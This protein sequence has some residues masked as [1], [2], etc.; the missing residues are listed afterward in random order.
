MASSTL[1]ATSSTPIFELRRATIDRI[2]SSSCL[3]QEQRNELAPQMCP[4]SLTSLQK[5]TSL[6]PSA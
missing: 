6:G 1:A 5:E 3:K 4:P 2:A